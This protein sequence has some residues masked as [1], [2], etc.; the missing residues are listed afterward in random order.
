MDV[1]ELTRKLIAC[2]TTNPPGGEAQCVSLLAGWLEAAG[3]SV[4]AV[5]YGPARAGLV[6]RRGASRGNDYLCFSGHLD[7]VPLGGAPWRHDA[8]AGEI[9]QG[10]LYGRGASDMKGGLAAIVAAV[11]RAASGPSGRDLPGLLLVFTADEENGCGGVK[12]LEPLLRAFGKPKGVIIG[13][14][15]LNR[16][17]LGHK[18]LLW[19]KATAEGKAAHGSRPELGV[20]AINKLARAVC[21][22][23]ALHFG[24]APHPVLGPATL[25]IGIIAGG[26][27]PNAVPDRAEMQADVR[28]TPSHDAASLLEQIRACAGK[29]IT[30][31]ITQ[32]LD[33]VWTDAGHPFVEQVGRALECEAGTRPE[34]TFVHYATDG[35]VLKTVFAH[36][37]IVIL[38]PGDPAAAHITDEYCDLSK[39]QDAVEIYE[40][41]LSA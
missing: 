26:T 38:G 32:Q 21:R 28:T 17:A 11:C 4:D 30:W 5:P 37:P 39:L 2:N 10:R 3:F 1:C 36:V 25:N 41:L 6:A 15:T 31:E 22:L 16:P 24:G 34:Y 14:P 9:D 35:A 40:R 20:N 7:T 19:L 23:E 8:F 33:P 18:G 29:D 27:R 12:T 13:E